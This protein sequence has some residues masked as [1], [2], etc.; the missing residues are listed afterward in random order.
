M[1]HPVDAERISDPPDAPTIDGQTSGKTGKEYEY[2]FNATDPDGDDVKYY[3][4]WG[5]NNTEWTDFNAS[6]TE[7][8]VKHTWSNDGTYNITAKAQD[9]YGFEGPEGTLTVTI[10][11]SRAIYYPLHLWFLERFPL[12]ERLL[13]FIKQS[14]ISKW[15]L[16]CLKI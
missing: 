7:I 13:L 2:T 6:G 1:I 3:I 14:F 5:D 9:I 16:R 10:P 12:L 15:T 4:E 11:R 8:K